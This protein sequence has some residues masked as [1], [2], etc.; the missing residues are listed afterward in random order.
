MG[1][2]MALEVLMLMEELVVMED[3]SIVRRSALREIVCLQCLL[4]EVISLVTR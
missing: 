4:D 3:M 1:M 2:L